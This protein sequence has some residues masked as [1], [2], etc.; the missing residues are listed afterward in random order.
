MRL[1]D[2]MALLDFTQRIALIKNECSFET[3]QYAVEHARTIEAEPVRHGHWISDSN[4][5]FYGTKKIER[6]DVV[7][8]IDGSPVCSCYC[9]VCGEWLFGEWLVGSDEY[10]ALGKYCPNCGAKMDEVDE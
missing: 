8:I 4:T 5:F 10:A 9:S 1:I 6:G 7:P 2:A 3:F